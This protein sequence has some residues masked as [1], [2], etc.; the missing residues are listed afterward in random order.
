MITTWTDL[1][2][3]QQIYMGEKSRGSYEAEILN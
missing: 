3:R 2:E 1:N